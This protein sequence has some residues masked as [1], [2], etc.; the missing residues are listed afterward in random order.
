MG[1][2]VKSHATT[3]EEQH[4]VRW[5]L[6]VACLGAAGI[7]VGLGLIVWSAFLPHSDAIVFTSPGET[8]VQVPSPGSYLVWSEGGY[9][10]DLRVG[11]VRLDVLAP[12]GTAVALTPARGQSVRASMPGHTYSRQSFAAFDTSVPGQYRVRVTVDGPSRTFAITRDPGLTGW[13]F[14]L[15]FGS[16]AVMVV[17]GLRAFLK[18]DRLK[19]ASSSQTLEASNN[20]ENHP[21]A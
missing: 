19:T 1:G 5:P 4:A 2:L 8:A 20:A 21:T 18:L 7:V 12:D 17:G 14:A 11:D 13:G 9:A 15:A 16:G 3:P 6:R 10:V